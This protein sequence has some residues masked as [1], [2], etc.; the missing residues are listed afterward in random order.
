MS[1]HLNEDLWKK[2]TLVSKGISNL[3]WKY[4]NFYIY[5]S[6]ETA[7]LEFGTNVYLNENGMFSVKLDDGTEYAL[8]RHCPH[9]IYDLYDAKI[10]SNDINYKDDIDI[11]RK[12]NAFDKFEPF[13]KWM[14]GFS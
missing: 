11:I 1:E 4:T 6:V 7:L 9:L 5:A 12:S 3:I 8:I 10:K 13:F 14:I 2:S